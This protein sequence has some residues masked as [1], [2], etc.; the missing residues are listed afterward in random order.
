MLEANISLQ[1]HIDLVALKIGWFGKRLR[2]A[3][4]FSMQKV[5]QLPAYVLIYFFPLIL[6]SCCRLGATAFGCQ[7]FIRSVFT[8]K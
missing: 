7:C 4:A 2:V 5:V 3:N 6:P 8:K 1:I